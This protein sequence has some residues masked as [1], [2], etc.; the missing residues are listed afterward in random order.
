MSKNVLL[1]GASGLVGNNLLNVL[2]KNDSNLVL[3]SRKKINTKKEIKQIVTNFDELE[4]LNNKISIDTVYI[5]IGK[6][7]SLMELIYLKKKNRS[8]FEK[9]DFEYIKNI[10]AF[11]KRSGAKSLGLISAVGA[12][13]NSLNTYLKVKGKTEEEIMSLGFDKVIIARPGHLLG[14]RKNESINPIIFIFEMITN[15]TGM[16][17]LGPLK[18]FKNIDSSKVASAIIEKINTGPDGVYFLDYDDFRNY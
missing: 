14:K 4:Q 13:K 1:A 17:L 5:A 6:R 16:L 18:K 12:N 11:A 3:I 2:L 7:L 10:A 8:N 9:V 15:I